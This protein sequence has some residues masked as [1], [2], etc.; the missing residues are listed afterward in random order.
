MTSIIISGENLYNKSKIEVKSENGK[1]F[2]FTIFPYFVIYSSKYLRSQYQ[3][4]YADSTIQLDFVVQKKAMSSLL[5]IIHQQ[6]VSIDFDEF[7][8][9]CSLAVQLKVENIYPLI[10]ETINKYKLDGFKK[11]FEEWINNTQIDNCSES[12]ITIPQDS[13]EF[14]QF[15]KNM[16]NNDK[17][18]ATDILIHHDISLISPQDLK[19]INQVFQLPIIYSFINYNHEFELQSDKIDDLQNQN[20]ILYNE[21]RDLRLLLDTSNTINADNIKENTNNLIDNITQ[22]NSFEHNQNIEMPNELSF[23]SLHSYHADLF[24]SLYQNYYKN[25]NDSFLKLHNE[26]THNNVLHEIAQ[27]TQNGNILD[28]LYSYENNSELDS[29][30]NE[31]NQ[32]KQTPIEIAIQCQNSKFIQSAFSHCTII[33]PFIK[34]IHSN[35]SPYENACISLNIEVFKPF[36]ENSYFDEYLLKPFQRDK[37]IPI[38]YIIKNDNEEKKYFAFFVE[39]YKKMKMILHGAINIPL[40][41]GENIAQFAQKLNKTSILHYIISDNSFDKDTPINNSQMLD[42]NIPSGK[43]NYSLLH[44]ASIH[45][46]LKTV[47]LLLQTHRVNVDLR[48]KDQKTAFLCSVIG[49]DK[50]L[51]LECLLKE[52]PDLIY[53]KTAEGKNALHFSCQ[54]GNINCA[55]YIIEKN[56]KLDINTPDKRGYTPLHYAAQ[57]NKLEDCQY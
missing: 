52:D 53:D 18:K 6:T 29:L 20:N 16:Y 55:K 54:K 3:D 15:I 34:H 57:N 41:N 11:E 13:N 51:C 4:K 33:D 43:N 26:I 12:N 2:K 27:N 17:K 9:M 35:N 10:L 48:S 28:I 14:T 56:K 37:L 24:Q 32:E 30:L 36:L 46:D 1:E 22:S 39:I 45:G 23:D 49:P 19:E 42:L 8:S 47:E 38:F 44:I 40:N 7:K 21:I 25:N 31:T 5:K 50:T